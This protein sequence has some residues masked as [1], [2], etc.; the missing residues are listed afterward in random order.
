MRLP[1]DQDGSPTAIGD[2]IGWVESNG[3]EMT[4]IVVGIVRGGGGALVPRTA[5]GREPGVWR[6]CPKETFESIVT[7]LSNGRCGDDEAVRRC[8]ALAE[9]LGTDA[10][11][12]T[13]MVG[14]MV[15]RGRVESGEQG[16]VMGSAVGRDGQPCL[17]VNASAPDGCVT[18]T[19]R[20]WLWPR[21]TCHKLEV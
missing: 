10:D 15:S 20:T 7:D 5:G 4:G 2:R 21:S 12:S 3:C 13:V 9:G 18:G 17:C 19:W 8:K 16:I 14:D 11:G 1:V 6:R